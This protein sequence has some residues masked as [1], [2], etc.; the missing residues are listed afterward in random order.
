MRRPRVSDAAQI[1]GLFLCFGLAIAAF[2]PFLALYLERYHGLDASRIGVVIACCAAARMV[3][4]PFWGHTADTRWGRL[5]VLQVCLVGS[6]V[7]A[8][9][10]NIHWAFAGVVIAA[11][12][13]SA[14]LVG[15]GPNIDALA[16]AHLGEERMSDYGRIRGWES[17]TYA[18]GCLV[19]GFIL[20]RYGMGWAMPLFAISALVVLVWSTTV[21]RDRPTQLEDHGRLG[22]VGAV[23]RE[24]PRFWGYLAA[25]L[26]VWIGFN[27]AWNFLALRIADNGGGAW[28]IGFGTAL[29][30]MVELPTMRSSSRLQRRLGLR[31]VYMIGCAVYALGFLLWG[32][33]SNPTVLSVL[34]M[35][36]GVGFS[37]LFTT[38]VV[39]I[40]RL[41]P[42][43][44][45]STGNAVSAMVA[46][47][48]API[49]GAG[50]GGFIYQ[51]LGA[52][53]LY[54]SASALAASAAVVA[55][56]ALNTPTLRDPGTTEED[57]AVPITLPDTGPT[58]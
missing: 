37:L 19:F 55:W 14:F 29:G 49:I 50:L 10:L 2:F 17:V 35:L 30:G 43:S 24:A 47:G 6:A 9:V 8:L 38:G 13:H 32:S 3:A 1:Q 48:I 53:V 51:H 56:F 26:L 36:E 44:L 11:A 41:L 25:A 54:G 5:A 39:I 31:R 7:A 27:A 52:P 58:V 46:F 28:L 45:Y 33:V 21:E 22:A 16:L 40:G 18:A 20:E 34:T 23:F 42:A 57:D 4:N 12:I 15:P